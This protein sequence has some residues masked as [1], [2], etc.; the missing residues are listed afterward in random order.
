[1]KLIISLSIN[2]GSTSI[3]GSSFTLPRSLILSILTYS[4]ES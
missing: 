3:I 1:M 2:V 4:C